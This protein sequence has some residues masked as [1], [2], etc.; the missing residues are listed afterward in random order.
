MEVLDSNF[1]LVLLKRRRRQHRV[2]PIYRYRVI[3][4]NIENEILEVEQAMHAKV[5]TS[6]PITGE[7]I[8]RILTKPS[9]TLNHSSFKE[10]K[11]IE[12]GHLSKNGF[13][14]FQKDRSNPKGYTWTVGKE[15]P[16]EINLA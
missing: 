3:D 4:S 15:G 7:P 13:T 2:M 10:K 14:V 1:P 8:E 11:G 6:H 12:H 9:L 16:E 5:L